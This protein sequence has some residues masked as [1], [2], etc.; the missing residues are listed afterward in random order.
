MI[1]QKFL[2]PKN[3]YAFKKIFGTEKNQDVLIPF[4]NSVLDLPHPIHSVTFLSLQI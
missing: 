3:D 2:D 1:F 4:L